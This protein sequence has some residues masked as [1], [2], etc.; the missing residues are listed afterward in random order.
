[1][2]GKAGRE[3]RER[4][5]CLLLPSVALFMLNREKQQKLPSVRRPRRA[6]RCDRGRGDH[7]HDM[8]CLVRLQNKPKKLVLPDQ[9]EHGGAQ[10]ESH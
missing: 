6:C 5:G 2:K 1:M 10:P 3:W 4:N 9:L 8:H 7:A